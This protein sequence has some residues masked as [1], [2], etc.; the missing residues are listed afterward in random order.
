M[1]R[2]DGKGYMVKDNG[3]VFRVVND[4]TWSLRARLLDM[5]KTNVDIQV[6]STVPVMFSYWVS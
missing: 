1:T 4:N 2:Q 6:L 5:E 3:D